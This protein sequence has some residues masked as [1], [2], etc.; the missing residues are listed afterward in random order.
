MRL[1][2]DIILVAYLAAILA[3]SYCSKYGDAYAVAAMCLMGVMCSL[4]IV[5]AVIAALD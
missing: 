1:R 3:L 2:L 5:L 4:G